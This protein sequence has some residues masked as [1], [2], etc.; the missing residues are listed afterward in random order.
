MSITEVEKL[1]LELPTS[2]RGRLAEKLIKS[3]PGPFVEEDDDEG[4]EEAIRRSRQMDEDP[5]MSLTEEE[6]L[7]C[8]EKYRR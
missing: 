6:F 5:E 3:L 8:F 7:A 2:E 1:A 4:V